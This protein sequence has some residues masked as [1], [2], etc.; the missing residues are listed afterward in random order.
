M[1]LSLLLEVLVVAAPFQMQISVDQAVQAGDGRLVW[2]LGAAFTAVVLVQ[3]SISLVRAWATAVFGMRIGYELM[4]RFVRALHRK[5]ARFHLK[6]HTADILSR[7]RSVQA[8]QTIVSAQMIQAL[9]DA[10]MSV[11]LVVGD[12]PL[13]CRCLRRSLSAS[14]CS[15][16]PPPRRFGRRRSKTSRRAVRVA[17]KAD[18]TFLEKRTRSAGDQAVRQGDGACHGLA[19]QVRRAHQLATRG[20]GGC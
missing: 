17:A 1:C 8:I 12:V 14:A 13:L 20:R 2:I 19:Q 18:A 7:G 11:V 15:T 10:V 9:L 5:S 16:S 3:A 6:H 4:D